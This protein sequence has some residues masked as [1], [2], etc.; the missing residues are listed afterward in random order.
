MQKIGRNDKCPCGS[1][2]KY[3]KCCLDKPVEVTILKSTRHIITAEK[4][5][6][7]YKLF[8]IF[9]GEDG[10]LYVDFPYL[11]MDGMVSLMK[12]DPSLKYPANVSMQPGG[13]V[14]SQLVKYSHHIDGETHFSQNGKVFT[15]IRK[16]AVPLTD[17]TGHIFTVM[18]Q[19]VAGFT[20]TGKESDKNHYD[21]ERSVLK[22]DVD[23]LKFDAL[24]FVGMW[25]SW[26]Y[27]SSHLG[28]PTP[29][30]KK[31][32]PQI[33]MDKDGKKVLGFLLGPPVGSPMENQVLYLTCEAHPA[34]SENHP[35]QLA[36][37]GGFDSKEQV[38]DL[39]APTSMLVLAYPIENYEKLKEEIGTID[40]RQDKP[41]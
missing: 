10:T 7:I 28:A 34:I 38:F 2:N 12:L 33:V 36:F 24:K 8:Q 41:I 14:T 39:T 26:D 9:F 32:G 16:K 15:E 21:P 40:Y 30:A 5:G 23:G 1:G 29:Y 6:K 13:K 27:L 35:S 37:I 4:D 31:I 19:G 20:S 18:L 3:K 22:F 17:I 11:K 25:Y